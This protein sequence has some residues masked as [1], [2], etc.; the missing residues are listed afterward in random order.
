LPVVYSQTGADST[1]TALKNNRLICVRDAINSKT[2]AAWTGAGSTAVLI[3]GTAS[4]ATTAGAGA[5]AGELA[6]FTLPNPVGTVATGV[7]T[8][9]GTPINNTGTA[10]AGTAALA[11]IRDAAGNVIVSGLTVGIT[12]S[13]SDVIIDSVT[14]SAGQ[15][16]TFVSGTISHA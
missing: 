16:V 3:V 2:P 6:R 4:L 15:V 8:F 5:V 12:G 7:L 11:Q 1:N 13:G 10:V 9:S 14:V